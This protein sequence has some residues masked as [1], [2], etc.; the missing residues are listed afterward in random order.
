MT[1]MSI[2]A[3]YPPDPSEYT[4]THGVLGVGYVVR[5]Q[6][7]L[8]GVA[9][10]PVRATRIVTSDIAVQTHRIDTAHHHGVMF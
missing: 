7:R 2:D 5:H 10:D 4:I 3:Q 8:L 9:L 1:M 6:G